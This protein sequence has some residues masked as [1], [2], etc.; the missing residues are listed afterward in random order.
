MFSIEHLHT[1]RAHELGQ[2][3]AQFPPGATLLEIGAGTGAQAL[4]LARLGFQVTAI[5]LAQSGYAEHRV[6]PVL[7]YDGVHLPCADGSLD[8]VFSSNV[9]EHVRDLEPLQQEIRR[10]LKPGGY[11]VHVL[12]TGAWRFWTS[13]AAFGDSLERIRPQLPELLPHWPSLA[14]PRRLL[15]AWGRVGNEALRPWTL[16][17]HGE[18][19]NAFTELWTFSRAR[20]VRLF[21]RQGFRVEL[22]K[23]MGL[24][25][26]G[27]MVLGARWS[28]ER[29]QRLAPWLGS[30]CCIYRLRPVA[31]DAAVG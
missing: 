31:Q 17:P 4:E 8:L 3:V 7:D 2:I 27:Y 26:T 22:A 13:L 21:R 20:W 1:L 14:E 24:F 15:G 19:G 23:P 5:D 9:L 10:V 28:L 12:P 6:Y 30:A 18:T 29:R 11:C 16:K 25:Y